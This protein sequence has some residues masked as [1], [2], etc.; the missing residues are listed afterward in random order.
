MKASYVILD[1]LNTPEQVRSHQVRQS[2]HAAML[3]CDPYYIKVR[4]SPFYS[5]LCHAFEKAFSKHLCG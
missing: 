5:N 3:G 1:D 4:K 2:Q